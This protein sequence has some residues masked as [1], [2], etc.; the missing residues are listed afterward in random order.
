MSTICL[1]FVAFVAAVHVAVAQPGAKAGVNY[2]WPD[3]NYSNDEIHYESTRLLNSPFVCKWGVSIPGINMNQAILV[4]PPCT[5][6]TP[7]WHSTTYEINYVLEGTLTYNVYP[8]AFAGKPT[9]P[10]AGKIPQ[11]DV[12]MAPLG[13]QH[14][15]SNN[16]CD[17][18]VM[19]HTFPSSTNEDFFN[20]W[21]NVQ[22]FPDSYLADVM[23]KNGNTV[24]DDLTMPDNLH[25]VNSQCMKTCGLTQ[26]YFDGF[27]CPE[28]IPLEKHIMAP[29]GP[30]PSPPSHVDADVLV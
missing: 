3:Y 13:V 11:G 6:I 16:E 8:Y 22:Q 12:F 25:T 1:S 20:T 14:L 7:H 4:L 15:I 21:L 30:T 2:F 24:K 23:P 29:L 17:M 19:A 27:K 10:L 9:P 5:Y 28:K 18:L 26:A